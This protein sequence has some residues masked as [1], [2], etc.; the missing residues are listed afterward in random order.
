M[1]MPSREEA[2]F[3]AAAALPGTERN[4]FLGR[5]CAGDPALRAR[6]DALLAAHEQ[7][8][9]LLAEHPEASRPTVTLEL[10]ELPDPAVG[11]TIGRYKLLER[12][13]EGGCGVVYVAEQT[14]P[15]RRRVALKVIKLG[16]DTREVIARFEAERQALALMDHPNIAKV[17]DAGTTE[18]GK[19]E[20][21]DQ[22][23]EIPSGRPYF[24][25]ELVRGI[26]ITDYCDQANLTTNDRLDLFIKVCQAIQHAHQKGIIHRDIK[27]SNILVTLHDGV[28]VP[29]VIDFGI[30]KATE[31]RLTDATVY[32]QLHQFIGTPA[33]MSP[34]QAEMSALDIDTRSD[35]YSLGVLLYELLTGR[36][37]F[38]P[39]ELMAQ[40]IDAM[41]KTIREKEPVRPST[42]L[43][44]LERDELTTTAKRRAVEAPRLV[45]LV[46][47]DL[48]WIVMKCL[49]KDRTRRYETANGLA[50]D[51]QRHL[52]NEPVVARP[53]S[54]LYRLQKAWR[55]HRFGFAA[56][57]T[58]GAVLLISVVVLTWALD[59]QK[60]AR[61]RAEEAQVEQGRERAK[62]EAAGQVAAKERDRAARL[63][64]VSQAVR[65]VELLE[66]HDPTGLLHLLEARKSVEHLP[67]ERLQ[68]TLLWSGWMNSLPKPEIR[69][70]KAPSALASAQDHF[71]GKPVAL[72]R[73]LPWIV[74]GSTNGE[75]TLSE[76]ATGKLVTRF[77][78]GNQR[79]GSPELSAN[80]RLLAVNVSGSFQ[81]WDLAPAHS[82]QPPRRLLGRIHRIAF[83]PEHRRVLTL[84]NQDMPVPGDPPEQQPDPATAFGY[85]LQIWD[86]T[87][88]P[89]LITTWEGDRQDLANHQFAF[90]SD[91]TKVAAATREISLWDARTGQP[92]KPP[93][94]TNGVAGARDFSDPF[95]FS[96]DGRWLWEVRRTA[97]L[98][99]D[100]NTGQLAAEP[101]TG[102]HRYQRPWLASGGAHL[103]VSLT[104]G[105]QV[106][107]LDRG[108]PMGPTIAL[109][110]DNVRAL[111]LSPYGLKLATAGPDRAL[112]VW[113]TTTGQQ[114]GPTHMPPTVTSSASFT[115]DGKGLEIFSRSIDFDT[116]GM[117]AT[118]GS[119]PARIISLEAPPPTWITNWAGV[120]VIG[121]RSDGELLTYTKSEGTMA[122]RDPATGRS[123]LSWPVAGSRA[124]I[125]S[126]LN[127]E[128]TLVAAAF[129]SGERFSEIQ[130][131]EA[132]SGRLL[133][134]A[135]TWTNQGA[136]A[137]SPDGQTLAGLGGYDG[138]G[139]IQLWDVTSRQP[140]AYFPS[141][142][143]EVSWLSLWFSPDGR[144]I[145]ARNSYAI[146]VW[147]VATGRLATGGEIDFYLAISDDWTRALG[148][149]LLDFTD[150]RNPRPAPSPLT[151]ASRGAATRRTGMA[152]SPDG[153][154]RAAEAGDRT[155]RLWDNLTDRPVG[156]EMKLANPARQ[157]FF[158]P[159]G[160]LL[161]VFEWAGFGG[162][163]G[164][165]MSLRLWETSTGLAC[166]PAIPARDLPVELLF[167]RDVRWLTQKAPFDTT[168]TL[169]IQLPQRDLS[170]SEMERQSWRLSGSRLDEAGNVEI[171]SDEEFLRLEATGD[172]QDSAGLPAV[173]AASRPEVS[174]AVA[175]PANSTLPSEIQN[176]IIAQE[177]RV[178]S[179]AT[180][181]NR[182][183][184][185]ALTNYFAAARSGN[186]LQASNAYA[187]F[188]SQIEQG[189]FDEGTALLFLLRQAAL[190]SYI[191]L[192][193][194]T[195]G[196]P[197][198]ATAF[199][200]D[201][202]ASLPAGSIYFGGT[203][204]G[205]G[206]VTAF[207]NSKSPAEAIFVLTQNALADGGYLT[208]A[209]ETYGHRIYVPTQDDLG[210]T[211][212]QYVSDAQDRLEHDRS[213]PAEPRQLKPGEEVKEVDGR[214]QISGQIAV[215]GVN[216]LLARAIF[217]QN[218]QRDFYVEE[219]F[220]LDWMYPHLEP[221]DLIMRLSRGP[222]AGIT[223]EAVRRDQ[224]FWS[225]Y[226]TPL[227]G[228]WLQEKTPVAEVCDF[229]A[230]VFVRKDLNGFNGDPAYVADSYA[231]KAFSKLRGSQ[232]GL[233]QWRATQAQDDAERQA[234]RRAADFASRQALALCPYSPEVV[235]RYA[236]ALTSEGRTED[237]LR[238]ARL[239]AQFPELRARAS[240]LIQGSD[241]TPEANPQP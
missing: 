46:T 107:H 23:S 50:A 106:L 204:A 128:G 49:E 179:L 83:D 55:R 58:V 237:A 21:R 38:D 118:S 35:I 159:D 146:S 142:P 178:H 241:S 208:Y 195:Q 101:V 196:Q 113:D 93:L 205:R 154:L 29:K 168:E 40:G 9:G 3:Q 28:P 110:D 181:Q 59:D 147:D 173:P 79:V 156:H 175:A 148:Q 45:R 36:P 162:R 125:G 199:G 89:C 192:E 22:R 190:D 228:G 99:Y 78:T 132:V 97:C 4:A 150:P 191:A 194:F 82:N 117:S 56:G 226:L 84:A 70:V 233:Y 64:S 72:R 240:Q 112:R 120:R 176:F 160:R 69:V 87:V 171:I 116:R 180:R 86:S 114:A 184:P 153:R 139:S 185:A 24:V 60:K 91:G 52:Q 130:I 144:F 27:P 57:A 236:S 198:Y 75:V 19:S 234:M 18:A 223:P 25:M 5:E 136:L 20:I 2:V 158:S 44:T 220:P 74:A 235:F 215:M 34:E 131:W 149:E 54:A 138:S 209:R 221:H 111:A 232:A 230:R 212:Q 238:V 7:S 71:G 218:P 51:L 177:E 115:A 12:L 170:L 119:G 167:D 67:E 10:S 182:P 152:L 26:K 143:K 48:D 188:S 102:L 124:M 73:G 81:L 127:P 210:R 203:D 32:T 96:P 31:G 104:N 109:T 47:G 68:R 94:S 37:P 134:P 151:A 15:V 219:S 80:G 108:E 141:A 206:L 165:G 140:R 225:R 1:T 105:F 169:F 200:R 164:P 129:R 39:R 174:R 224:E 211:F 163:A 166:G 90:S 133:E 17:L 65:G 100:L 41:R 122:W 62:A 137:F 161:V 172:R 126:A 222:L 53:P 155:M 13:G 77:S 63:L 88:E 30:A 229:A 157:Q 14:E 214:V 227:V 11:Q 16:M 201:V 95:W 6:L 239:A 213:F 231:C 42:R 216:A 103:V 135:I 98:R 193:F 207:A 92:A 85:Q 76:P 187:V 145:A 217:E 121:F 8:D 43:A 123:S 186:W 202:V 183:L 33:Y 189:P 197:Q 66:K 61:K